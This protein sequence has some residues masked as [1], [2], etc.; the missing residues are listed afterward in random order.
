MT[1][2]TI[3]ASLWSLANSV[4]GFAIAQTLVFMYA[5]SGK[6][7]GDTLNRPKVRNAVL[8]FLIG[9]TTLFLGC[10][11][12][13]LHYCV[14]NDV[15]NRGFHVEAAIGRTFVVLLFGGIAIAFL[16]A[17]K[18]FAVQNGPETTMGDFKESES[19]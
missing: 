8:A 17:R 12:W 9:N 3:V 7:F 10:I 13:T 4:T 5:S 15:D 2:A 14:L 19:S 18:M 16:F 1:D 11:A 6:H